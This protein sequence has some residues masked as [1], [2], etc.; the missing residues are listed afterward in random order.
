MAL[1]PTLSTRCLVNRCWEPVKPSTEDKQIGFV[2][3]ESGV[4]MAYLNLFV[5]FVHFVQEPCRTWMLRKFW[6]IFRR[7]LHRPRAHYLLDLA[8]HLWSAR[9][10]WVPFASRLTQASGNPARPWNVPWTL[11]GVR[12]MAIKIWICPRLVGNSF[13][14]LLFNQCHQIS[15]PG[16]G[17]TD[18][19]FEKIGTGLGDPS[20][21][22]SAACA[23]C[24][25]LKPGDPDPV[26]VGNRHGGWELR[27]WNRL[28]GIL[29]DL[30][31]PTDLHGWAFGGNC[32]LAGP[33]LYWVG[34]GGLLPFPQHAHHP[35][36]LS[37]G[38][39]FATSHGPCSHGVILDPWGLG[40]CGEG[41]LQ[42]PSWRQCPINGIASRPFMRPE[43]TISSPSRWKSVRIWSSAARREGHEPGRA[44]GHDEAW[45]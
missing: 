21:C 2:V 25:A 34:W 35:A 18:D 11:F 39:A 38:A 8:T 31:Q 27:I 16:M 3:H 44:M 37:S 19:I 9:C 14:L 32:R 1:C 41:P 5:C 17:N 42:S 43:V 30:H 23:A 12:R 10:V 13:D 40:W 24:M 26:Q 28:Y 20:T 36:E 22:M 6:Q 4:L 33:G 15:S 7:R 45:H 29:Q